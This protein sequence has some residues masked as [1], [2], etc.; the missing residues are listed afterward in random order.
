ML[1]KQKGRGCWCVVAG[2]RRSEVLE[3]WRR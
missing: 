2:M 3:P 1:P